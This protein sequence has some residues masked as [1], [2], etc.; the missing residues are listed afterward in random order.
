M[1]SWCAYCQTWQG[2]I[3]PLESWEVTH[4]ICK[5]CIRRGVA[6]DAAAIGA[7]RPVADFLQALR[8]EARLG[9]STP[10]AV[11]LD[12]ATKLGIRPLE[13][14]VG[15]LQPALDEIGKL[16]EREELTVAHEHRFSAMVETV[17]TLVLQRARE[18]SAVS[19][20]P[21]FLLVNADGNHHTLGLRVV[22]AFLL[23]HGRTVLALVPGL[24]AAE[25]IAQVRALQPK[26]LGVSVA[27]PRELEV[28]K[29][30]ATALAALPSE[31]R[32]RF[33]A[34]GSAIRAGAQLDPSLGVIV[35]AELRDLLTHS[36]SADQAQV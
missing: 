26:T 17:V 30:I 15:L 23:S 10:G 13:L 19:S 35:C 31:R 9:F 5:S 6:Q 29:E 32:P 4:G 7:I 21:E 1:I 20:Q 28:V 2:E 3:P 34:G 8:A 11:V 24:P 12:R 22:E 33:V 27:V 18:A 16:W 14:L 25:V 36:A